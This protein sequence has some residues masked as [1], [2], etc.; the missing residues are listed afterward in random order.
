[1]IDK[2]SLAAESEKVLQQLM[3][4]GSFDELRKQVMEELKGHEVS[5]AYILR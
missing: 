1:M 2:L 3:D 4:N 5:E